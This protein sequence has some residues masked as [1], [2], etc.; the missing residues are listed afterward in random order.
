MKTTLM[1]EINTAVNDRRR[2]GVSRM[3]KHS[4]RTDMTPM[5]D[6]GFLLVTFFVFTSEIS[7]PAVTNLVMPKDAVDVEP[8]TLAE[9]NSLTIM[10]GKNST[11]FYY[12]GSWDE[13]V[14]KG[15]VKQTNF[16]FTGLGD[17]IRNK[18]EYL[19][20]HP[21]KGEGR[22]GLMLLIKPGPDASYSDVINLLDE[23]LINDVKKYAILKLSAEEAG[24]LKNI[25]QMNHRNSAGQARNNE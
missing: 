20:K 10:A 22:S 7:K 13:A 21:V 24:W 12:P 23:A 18:Q 3:K 5:V 14:K 25:E 19:D 8:I 15:A 11:L 6:L 4:L 16:S 1:A 2:A 9:S 17:I